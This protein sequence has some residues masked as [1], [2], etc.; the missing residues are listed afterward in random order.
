MSSNILTDPIPE[1]EQALKTNL[2]GIQPS[3]HVMLDRSFPHTAEDKAAI[4]EESKKT[5]RTSDRAVARARIM[6]LDG[7]GIGEMEVVLDQRGYTVERISDAASNLHTYLQQTYESLET[8]L[9]AVSPAYVQAMTMEVSKRFEGF[10]GRPENSTEE[11]PY[12][13]DRR[14]ENAA[15]GGEQKEWR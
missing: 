2:F 1:L 9:I 8:L 6:L 12:E 15:L 10:S 14:A 3:S 13:I 11:D 5:G 7:G 4:V